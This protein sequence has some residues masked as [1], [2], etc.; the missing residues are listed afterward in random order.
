MKA[1]VGTVYGVLLNFQGKYDEIKGQMSCP[2][3]QKEPEAPI[4]Y[5]KPRNTVSE[6]GRP[7]PL[8]KDVSELE[9]GAT[10]GVV[11]GEKATKVT[12]EK[13]LT[14]IAGYV[15][16][17]D[18]SIPHHHYFRPALKQQARDGFCP[19]G[20]FVEQDQVEDPGQL[21]IRVFVNGKLLQ[22]TSTRNLI[23][24]IPQLL[25]DITEFMTLYEGDL[26]LVGTAEG[27]PLAKEGDI[28]RIEIE[29]IGSLENPIVAEW[30]N[31]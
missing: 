8:P 29:S 22:V 10:L 27:A 9:I 19:V 18:V 4:L 17:N 23:R 2:P 1:V 5:I 24:S 26:L 15:V 20:S 28:V 11:I 16:V 3:Y 12:Y 13:A 31:L 30:R 25:V 14:Y 7:I 6:N 21:D